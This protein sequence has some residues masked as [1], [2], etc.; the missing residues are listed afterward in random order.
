MTPTDS[1]IFATLTLPSKKLWNCFAVS[2]SSMT[3]S[4][5]SPA[6]KVWWMSPPALVSSEISPRSAALDYKPTMAFSMSATGK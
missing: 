2:H 5:P 3:T 4:S 1:M 6:T